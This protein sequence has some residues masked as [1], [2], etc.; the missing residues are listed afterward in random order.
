M[1]KA[2]ICAAK[3][4]KKVTVMVEL[5][6]RFDEASNIG[7]SKKMQD[8]GIQVLFGV[9]GLKVHCKLTHIAS[10]KGNVACISTGNPH[11][12]IEWP[13]CDTLPTGHALAAIGPEF[14]HHPAFP[15][16][17][18]T[19][20]VYIESPTSVVMRVWE[21]GAGETLSC[22]TG[23][24]AVAVA[25]VENGFCTRGADI[26]VRLPGGTLVVRYQEDGKVWLTGDANTDF[27]GTI[28]I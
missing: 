27:T 15:E 24:C 18:N 8:A 25:A 13:D 16:G 12:I 4:G 21:R 10:T 5:M 23:A 20:F 14:E 17:V 26:D 7:W 9:E 11:C 6:A 3:H 28:E 1:V 19:E 22:G 2:L